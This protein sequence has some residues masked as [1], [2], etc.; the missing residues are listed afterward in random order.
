MSKLP[1]VTFARNIVKV[2]DVAESQTTNNG[3][4]K[5]LL[6]IRPKFSSL[7]EKSTYDDV[8]E[9]YCDLDDLS[10]SGSEHA[11]GWDVPRFENTVKKYAK[12]AENWLRHNKTE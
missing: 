6:I 9:L 5:A 11:T 12:A 10:E 3:E 4:H 1:I 7:T 8:E 2:I